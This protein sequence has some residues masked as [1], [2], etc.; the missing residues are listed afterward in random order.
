[1][2]INFYES[3]ARC[4]INSPLKEAY[5]LAGQQLNGVGPTEIHQAI[6]D[7]SE[8]EI[9][10]QTRLQRDYN[11]LPT[12]T[13]NSM[14]ADGVSGFVDIKGLIVE[15]S[16]AQIGDDSWRV[17]FS[18][19]DAGLLHMTTKKRL[20]ELDSKLASIV[21]DAEQL[22]E[23]TVGTFER[24]RNAHNEAVKKRIAAAAETDAKYPGMSDG[25]WR[26]FR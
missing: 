20:D 18:R 11:M 6:L 13:S 19:V 17:L 3:I 4:L 2:S 5:V 24:Q 16:I 15:F 22:R 12:G 21:N 10:P 14:F 8:E 7:F 26:V 1:M 23:Y 9:S 25:T